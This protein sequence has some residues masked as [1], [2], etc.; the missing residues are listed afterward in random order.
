MNS[1]EVDFLS[2]KPKVGRSVS[3]L[4]L[5]DAL[6]LK[7]SPLVL[8]GALA[9]AGVLVGGL[10]AFKKGNQNASQ[11]LMRTRVVFQAATVA[12]SAWC[13]KMCVCHL[14]STLF[15]SACNVDNRICA[16]SPVMWSCVLLASLRRSRAVVPSCAVP[17]SLCAQAFTQNASPETKQLLDAALLEVPTRGWTEEALRA[18]AASAGLSPAAV[19][20]FLHFTRAPHTLL[21]FRSKRFAPTWCCG[22]G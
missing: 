20:A 11:A 12:I 1:E 4:S 2:G 10:V 8:V 15:R 21:T 5:P 16:P 7:K 13:I 17:R 6:S 9:T 14:T 3:F 19:G 22:A 18:G